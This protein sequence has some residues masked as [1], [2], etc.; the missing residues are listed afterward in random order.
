ME[1]VKEK[2]YKVLSQ[3]P[4]KIS[5]PE[6]LYFLQN[7]EINWSHMKA[8]K[9]ISSLQDETI[10]E[11]FNIS[12]KTLRNYK[13]PGNSLKNN[14]KE[15]LILLLSLFKH[16]KEVFGTNEQF[17]QWLHSKNFY[18]DNNSPVKFLNTITG[19]RFVSDRLSAM[20]YGDNA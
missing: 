9:D 19:I 16:G 4:D 6:V 5:E 18:F 1:A 20:E 2:K 17:N 3:I 14:I 15:Q 8:L 13:K 12:V 10:S 11:W 7:K